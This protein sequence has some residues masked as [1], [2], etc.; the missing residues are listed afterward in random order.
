MN[1]GLYIDSYYPD[2]HD[3]W[4]TNLESIEGSILF[5]NNSQAIKTELPIMSAHNI[6]SFHDIVIADCFLSGRYLYECPVPRRKLLL[7]QN[8]DWNSSIFQSIDHMKVYTGLEILS[9]NDEIHDI[10][11]NVWKITPT[12][13]EDLRD[14]KW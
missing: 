6:W 10:L 12:R 14:V 5:I 2:L 11:R 7:A 13:I 9:V 1:I 8:V 3:K 4:I